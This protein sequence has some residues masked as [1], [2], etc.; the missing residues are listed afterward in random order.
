MFLADVLK[1]EI[2][3]L[4]KF[5]QIKQDYAKTTWPIFTELDM[6]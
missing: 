1:Y 4:I 5:V 3:L 6:H 2:F